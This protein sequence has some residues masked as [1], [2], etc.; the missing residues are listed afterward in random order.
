MK[1]F[2][3]GKKYFGRFLTN[4][5]LKETIEVVSISK[6]RKS[7]K[8]KKEG[9]DKII[10][11]KIYDF[12][13][14]CECIYPDGFYSMC[15]CITSEKE[16]VEEEEKED[17]E[18]IDEKKLEEA[19]N[20]AE[21]VTQNLIGEEE[22]V[23][24]S[25]DEEGIQM[26]L[27][28]DEFSPDKFEMLADMICNN[29]GLSNVYSEFVWK[30]IVLTEF[31]YVYGDYFEN[32]KKDKF[33]ADIDF[34]GEEGTLPTVMVITNMDTGKTTIFPEEQ[35]V[36]QEEVE[37]M[38]A[39]ATKD[40]KPK[41]L[42]EKPC[43][44]TSI[45]KGMVNSTN[46]TFKN[47]QASIEE[48]ENIVFEMEKEYRLPT[49]TIEKANH[50]NFIT[51]R[52]VSKIH[53][54]G[55][56][57]TTDISISILAQLIIHTYKYNEIWKSHIEE[58]IKEEVYLRNLKKSIDKYINNQCHT[59]E[60]KK[61]VVDLLDKIIEKTKVDEE[62]RVKFNLWLSGKTSTVALREIAKEVGYDF[63]RKDINSHLY[64]ANSIN[65]ID[66]AHFLQKQI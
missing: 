26:Q 15:M 21:H 25:E 57:I 14:E 58:F 44:L 29:L 11:K 51:K 19:L 20:V 47:L 32:G 54:S 39:S 46:V 35:K 37:K 23:Y 10:Q 63:W 22:Y 6:S 18:V 1:K 30:K 31:N 55:K 9:S 53:D 42:I 17:P 65:T 3:A 2:E 52:V 41:E 62:Y 24:L 43:V 48:I 33:I 34:R 27:R 59:D 45:K 16:A 40:Q 5:D 28:Q 12:D 50:I 66:S 60:L 7:L 36:D 4:H 64:I 49:I 56:K 61:H 13:N 38:I 8:F